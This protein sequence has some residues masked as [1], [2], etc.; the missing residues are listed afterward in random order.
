MSGIGGSIGRLTQP[1]YT[2]E[3]RCLPCTV[4]NVG[5]AVVL[6]VGVAFINPIIG[7]I[8]FGLSLAAIY[9][10]GYLIPGTPELTKRYM[11]PWLLR[12]FGKEPPD[13]A[14]VIEQDRVGGEP[15]STRPPPDS[16]PDAID[17]ETQLKAAGVVEECDGVDDLCLT[18]GFRSVWWRRI[19]RLRDDE[20]SAV[21]HLG[22]LLE[23]DPELLAFDDDGPRFTVR[24]DGTPVGAWD[25]AAAFY[26]D[27]AVEPTLD[28]WLP[29][30]ESIGDAGRTQLIA[31]MRAFLERCP[32]CEATLEP[33][34]NVRETCCSAQVVGVSVDCPD[35]EARVFSGR[36]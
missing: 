26:T 29:A 24:Y 1:E 25:S 22:A 31:S 3:N 27:L 9:L 34:E 17:P 11:P 15:D 4:L 13:A 30:W 21:I 8:V 28:E 35:C 18:E 7:A 16:D 5:I 19:R 6:A 23:V 12:R 14:G 20:S 32:S 10:R 33:V 36:Y 2:G